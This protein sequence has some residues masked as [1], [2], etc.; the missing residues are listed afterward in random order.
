MRVIHIV[1]GRAN[2]NRMN[3]VNR[4]VHELASTQVKQGYQVEVWG[5]TRS[6][7]KDHLIRK[8]S[9]KVFRKHY[10]SLDENLK[11]SIAKCGSIPDVVFHIHGGF[12]YDFFLVSKLL[13]K[14]C[15]KY[16]FTSHGCY[17]EEAVKKN[18][19][20]KWLF[21]LFFE[22]FI[23][24]SAWK[25]HFLNSQESRL[26]CFPEI[27][28]NKIVIPNG[29]DLEVFHF[30]TRQ[31]ENKKPVVFGYVGRLD[32]KHKG[33]DILLEGFRAYIAEGGEGF[34][35]LVGGG[36]DQNQLEKL[37]ARYDLGKRVQF[38]G[39]KFGKEKID[40]MTRMDA[41][42]HSSRYEGFPMAPIEAAALGIPLIVSKE[43]HL[44]AYVQSFKCGVVL[45]ENNG[46]CLS[47]AFH[48][49]D[50]LY[51]QGALLDIGRN[52]RLMCEREFDWEQ[53]SRKLLANEKN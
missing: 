51:S 47:R 46:V 18:F 41:F 15:I 32:V 27:V 42:V 43:T 10:F 6:K 12:I 25:V 29:I 40:L 4:V 26:S 8:Y 20:L 17:N 2:P 14:F 31:T 24:K 5:L 38:L 23:L 36:Q 28:A 13:N 9:L 35:W 39:A 3:G 53:I 21:F 11:S 1:L 33:L 48:Q 45:Q 16:I 37:A 19:I 7:S 50:E 22:R 44:N 30:Q 34:L 49:I 52:A